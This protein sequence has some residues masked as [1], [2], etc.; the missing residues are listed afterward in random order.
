MKRILDASQNS[1]LSFFVGA[2]VS[3]LSNAPTWKALINAMCDKMGREKKDDYSSDEYLQIPQMFYYS[4]GE[5]KSEYNKFV[6]E[7]LHSNELSPND[8]HH[9]MLDLNPASF[10]TTNYDT[11]IEDA[12]LHHCKSYK[13]VACDV[14]VPQIY[15]DRF[16]LKVHGDFLNNNIVL[17]EEDYLNYSESFKL[18]ETLTKSIFSTNTV[19]FIGYGLNDYNIKL[20][21]NWAKSLL[22]EKFLEPIF[23]YT[24][25]QKLTNEELIYHKSKGLSVIEWYKLAPHPCDYL[26]RYRAFF[27]ALRKNSELSLK[28]KTEDEA[29]EMLYDL[30]KPLN[31]LNTLRKGDVSKRIPSH[32]IITEDGVIHLSND[33]IILKKFFYINQMTETQKN[34]LDE[35]TLDK[36]NCILKVFEKARILEVEENFKNRPFIKD[37]PFADINCIQFDFTLMREFSA[38][39]YTSIEKNYKKAFYLSRLK[40]YDEAFFLFSEVAKQAFKDN[41]YLLYYFAESNCISLRNIIRN[42]NQLFCCYDLSKIELLSPNDLEVENLFRCLPV[43]FRNTYDNLKD[44]HSANMLYRYSY[45][46]FIDGQ[47]LQN[48]IESE[49][50]EFG[51]TSSGKAICKINDYLHFL[52]G[53]GIIAEVFAEYKSTVKNLMSLL[54]YKCSVQDKKSLHDRMFPF[55]SA[56]KVYFDEIDFY[57]F[58][59]CFSGK[60]IQM[61]FNKH[62]IET[63]EFRNLNLIEASVNNLIDY[64]DYAVRNS[65]NNVDVISLQMQIKTCLSI[66]RYINISQE[67]VDRIVGFV[68]SYDF[69]ELLINDKVLFIDSQLIRRK[70]YSDNTSRIIEDALISYMDK[71]IFALENEQQ[72][73]LPSTSSGINYYNLIHYAYLKENSSASRRLSLRISHILT[74]E[75]TPMY[76]HI[77]NHY[78][79]YVSFYQKKRLVSWAN[80]QLVNSFNFDIFSMLV[81]LNAHLS[82]TIKNQLKLFLTKKIELAKSNEN[83]PNGVIV[84]PKHNPYK[85]LDQ[86]GYW[87][88]IKVLQAKDFKEFLGYSPKFDFYCEYE[89]F[90]FSRFEVSWLLCLYPHALTVISKNKSVKDKIRKRIA[91]E[92]KNKALVESDANKL[93]N[94]LID[95]FC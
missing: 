76:S 93:Q 70:M 14:N 95:Y 49:S 24:G 84:Y 1:A 78:C 20:I 77:A 59:D 57:C 11:L 56:D 52:Q 39:K 64:Y 27:D 12:A 22:K 88:L 19:V 43:E 46:A 54:V 13:V 66:L 6:K 28:E 61:L 68:F 36:Y 25:E 40:R 21:V 18:I 23:I 65:K 2:G 31:K 71:H 80:K 44:I 79:S 42:T 10:M 83:N 67:L 73:D 15:G 5:K 81:K 85:E 16:I 4:L 75:L 94:I 41:N 60:E 62:K 72:F 82:P 89:K 53:N 35:E 32:I 86:V 17:K 34:S 30:L 26:S 47:N 29:F 37:A 58:I 48:A 55:D 50:T 92:L 7:Q 63:I 69:R 45:E 74:K 51:L 90:D 87:C 3:A 38:K 91:S 33:D 9:E 8:I